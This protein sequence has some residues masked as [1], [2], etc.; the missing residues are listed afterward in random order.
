M[1]KVNVGLKSQI[2]TM[3][4]QFLKGLISFVFSFIFVVCLLYFVEYSTLRFC[5]AAAPPAGNNPAIYS[6]PLPPVVSFLFTIHSSFHKK[7]LGSHKNTN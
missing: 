5:M 4:I 3:D 6:H 1:S 2:S 7:Q